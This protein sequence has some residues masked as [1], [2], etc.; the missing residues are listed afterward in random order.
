MGSV[1]FFIVTCWV[2]PHNLTGGIYAEINTIEETHTESPRV[3]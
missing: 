1:A 2:D 3:F